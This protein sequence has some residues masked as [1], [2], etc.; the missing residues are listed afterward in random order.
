MFYETMNKG[1]NT[2]GSHNYI[3]VMLEYFVLEAEYATHD[4][5]VFHLAACSTYDIIRY[6]KYSKNDGPSPLTL[7]IIKQIIYQILVAIKSIN[8]NYNIL[9]TDIRAENILVLGINRKLA[10]FKQLF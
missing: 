3:N 2:G 1:G 8:N 4:C 9:H 7:N 6:I 5:F 10:L